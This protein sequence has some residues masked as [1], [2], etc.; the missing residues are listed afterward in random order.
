MSST[1]AISPT[2]LTLQQAIAEGYGA[3]S[4]LRKYIADG[5]LPAVKIGSRIKLLRTDL[6]ALKTPAGQTPVSEIEAAAERFAASAPP[7]TDAQVRRLAAIF[8]GAS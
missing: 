7:L 4:T 6:E 3:Y 5:R 2:Y 8:G 1:H